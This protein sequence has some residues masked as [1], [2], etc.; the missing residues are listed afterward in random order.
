MIS[1]NFVQAAIVAHLQGYGP[2][3][4]L[5]PDGAE[6]IREAEWKG[7]DFQYPCVRVQRSYLSAF[8]D[9]NCASRTSRVQV[10]ITA[11][12]K[13]DS[14]IV[15]QQIQGQIVAALD[16]QRFETSDAMIPFLRPQQVIPSTPGVGILADIW[17]GPVTFRGLAVQR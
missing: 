17:E 9:G 7:I 5:L 8:G 10:T 1:P 3:V 6:G 15:S 11:S 2:L 14:S 13:K 4:A 12:S 16:G